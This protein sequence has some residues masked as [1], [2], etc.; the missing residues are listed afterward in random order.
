MVKYNGVK[1]NYI[2][3][4]IKQTKFKDRGYIDNLIFL[5]DYILGK[6]KMTWSSSFIFNNLKNEYYKILKDLN[7][8]RYKKEINQKKKEE[9][10]DKR[11][12]EMF[13][14]E[15]LAEK[16]KDREDWVKAGGMK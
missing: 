12:E 1:S 13:R 14:K 4:K 2:R 11:E 15:E 5:E 6:R 10:D 8:Q 16:K 7:P 3:E 9:A